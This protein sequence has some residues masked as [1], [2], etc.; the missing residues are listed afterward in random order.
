MKYLVLWEYPYNAAY[1][2]PNQ[3]LTPYGFKTSKGNNIMRKR[4]LKYKILY[5]IIETLRTNSFLYVKN[6]N[7][8]NFLSKIVSVSGTY[9]N[10]RCGHFYDYE[11]CSRVIWSRICIR[12]RSIDGCLNRS[13]TLGKKIQITV[14]W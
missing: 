1:R 7:C 3:R 13:L 10:T 9:I 14:R 12:P 4:M 8:R 5:G 6:S 2:T 11:V